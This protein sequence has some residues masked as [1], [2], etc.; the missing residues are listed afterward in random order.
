MRLLKKN[1]TKPRKNR[2]IL[3][4]W[5]T[6]K[7]NQRQTNAF[8]WL[9]NV[10]SFVFYFHRRSIARSLALSLFCVSCHWISSIAAYIIELSLSNG[11]RKTAQF[12]FSLE[13][14]EHYHHQQR[15]R[16]FAVLFWFSYSSHLLLLPAWILPVCRQTQAQA[17]SMLLCV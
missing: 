4:I 14:S 1:E 5:G 7:K 10:F 13:Q 6:K 15:Q 3:G 2:G 11:R 8:Q 16:R 17:I 9:R 12:L